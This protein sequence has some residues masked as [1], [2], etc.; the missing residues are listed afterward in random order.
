MPQGINAASPCYT[1]WWTPGGAGQPPAGG[2]GSPAGSHAVTDAGR[3][4][5]GIV[6]TLPFPGS[7]RQGTMHREHRCVVLPDFQGLGFGTRISDRVAEA[8]VQRGV[9]YQSR[10]AHP[11][12]GTHRGR[13]ELWVGTTGNLKFNPLKVC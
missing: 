11:R 13:S 3:L 5:V 10:T 12:F 7:A 8:Y 1:A 2:E 4:A 9:R 6:C